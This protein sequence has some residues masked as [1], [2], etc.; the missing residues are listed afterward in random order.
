[1]SNQLCVRTMVRDDLPAIVPVLDGTGLFPAD[2]LADMAEPFLR[3]T[4][5]HLWLV[6]A[7]DGDVQGFAYCEPERATDGTFNLL[8]IAVNPAMHGSGIGSALIDALEHRL[9][10]RD[11][12]C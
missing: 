8:A 3:E 4:Q 7:I 5:P 9:R 1:M 6:G 2:L 11:A 10:E 12:P